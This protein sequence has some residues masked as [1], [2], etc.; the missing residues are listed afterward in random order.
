MSNAVVIKNYPKGL[1][2]ILDPNI[3]FDLLYTELGK[4]FRESSKFFGNAKLVISFEG[5]ELMPE[6]E[7]LLVDAIADNSDLTVLCTIGQGDDEKNQQY[8]KA[9]SR[10]L[11]EQ[12]KMMSKFCKGPI[13]AAEVV[14]SDTDLIVI[15]DV[16]PGA[17]VISS[18]NIIILGTLYGTA[19]AGAK[20]NEASFVVAL[21]LRPVK[22]C[23]G[24]K[25]MNI[26]SKRSLFKSKA[27]PKLVFI[28]DDELSVEEITAETVEQLQI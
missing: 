14:E 9:G 8:I 2:V 17:E 15:G 26:I 18:G 16:N 7:R 4:K 1:S 28:K 6:E 11:G 5:R 21:D 27:N 22:V 23:I 24:E 3:P 12:D 25:S 10:F 19:R 20:G 13:R